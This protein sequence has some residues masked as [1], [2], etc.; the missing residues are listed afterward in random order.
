[1]VALKPLK[2]SLKERKRYV[3]IKVTSEKNIP[4]N[5]I[6]ETI[7]RS[8]LDFM[9]ILLFGKAGMIILKNQ[10]SSDQGIIRINHKYVDFLKAALLEIKEIKKIKVNIEVC[11]VSGIIKKA[12]DK[13]IKIH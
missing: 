4:L 7:N 2:P 11:G 13:F 8:C 10:F 1:M 6:I 9:G 3:V 5:D 12:K